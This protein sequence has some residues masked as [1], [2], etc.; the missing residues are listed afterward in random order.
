MSR[1]SSG[2]STTFQQAVFARFGLVP[3]FFQSAAEAPETV[4]AVTN[5]AEAG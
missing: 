1:S 2:H 4:E 3:N 5:F